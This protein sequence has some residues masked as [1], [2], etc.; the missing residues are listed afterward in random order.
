[1]DPR[2]GLQG[3]DRK[4]E[5]DI[6]REPRCAA[7]LPGPSPGHP[8]GA[9]SK[10]AFLET[11]TVSSLFSP[12]IFPER[13]SDRVTTTGSCAFFAAATRASL[14]LARARRDAEPDAFAS[15]TD[16][17]RALLAADPSSRP[18]RASEPPAGPARRPSR[19]RELAGKTHASSWTT[20]SRARRAAGMPRLAVFAASI[21]ALA[22][23]L[24]P[25]NVAALSVGDIIKPIVRH[26]RGRAESPSRRAVV[27][28]SFPAREPRRFAFEPR[29]LTRA[30]PPATQAGAFGPARRDASPAA[31]EPRDWTP[32][33]RATHRRYDDR[34]RT[35]APSPDPPR[36]P[37]TRAKRLD[38]GTPSNK[39]NKL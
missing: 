22:L 35:A 39:E 24:A 29:A 5:R 15:A 20:P 19:S 36:F 7:E 3:P 4:Q 27:A 30:R 21:A 12:V 16:D 9:M 18:P 8:R 13:F 28:F 6:L 37:N 31:P 14:S 34:G 25:A 1:M 10:V 38:S 11:R 23:A 2:E 33:P 32:A 26:A 17:T